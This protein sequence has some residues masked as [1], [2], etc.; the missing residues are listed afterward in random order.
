[1]SQTSPKTETLPAD[2]EDLANFIYSIRSYDEAEA[3]AKL[4]WPLLGHA[5]TPAETRRAVIMECIRRLD[6][7]RCIPINSTYDRTEAL[8]DAQVSLRALSV[9]SPERS[10]K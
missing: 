3:K 8:K 6:D 10:S 7:L 2:E 4:L 9:T 5:Q 1:M